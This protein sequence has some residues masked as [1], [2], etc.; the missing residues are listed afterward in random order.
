[1]VSGVCRAPSSRTSHGR[2]ARARISSTTTPAMP[3]TA[4]C[5]A[6]R[7][8][9]ASKVSPQPSVSGG[10]TSVTR[11]AHPA[12]IMTIT[13]M[14]I[15]KRVSIST[16]SWR[17]PSFRHSEANQNPGAPNDLPVGFSPLRASR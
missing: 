7:L 3:R 2:A 16:A 12:A 15:S 5:R 4:T 6:D 17:L 9:V 8:T 10:E 13:A 11:K 1:M 14:S